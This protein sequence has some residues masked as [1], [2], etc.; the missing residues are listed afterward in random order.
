MNRGAV[1]SLLLLWAV[2][3]ALADAGNVMTDGVFI[4]HHPSSMQFTSDQT[5]YQPYLDEFAIASCQDQ[6]N[7]IDL[8]GTKGQISI[9]YVLAA[10]S[11]STS[12]GAAEFG[13]GDFR[14]NPDIYRFIEWGPCFPEKGLDISTDGWPGPNEGTAI[15]CTGAPWEGT[16]LPVYYFAGYAY[17]EGIIPLADN[18]QTDFIGTSVLLRRPPPVG[19][20]AE[21][22]GEMGLFRDGLTV[23]PPS[24][25]SASRLEEF[26][27]QLTSPP[28][29]PP[30][31]GASSRR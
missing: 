5:W 9:W 31:V 10:Y 4:A 7:R 2:G 25:S 14:P 27:S 19:R 12:W 23:C 17:A 21:A 30:P 26:Y 3:G 6:H 28:H 1:A 16:I 20:R 24:G 11:D 18:P 22:A 13:F 29:P 8:D 15:A